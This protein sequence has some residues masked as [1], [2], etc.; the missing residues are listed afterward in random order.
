D[1]HA[2]IEQPDILVIEGLNILQPGPVRADG[3][4]LRFVS[5]FIDFSIY[6]DADPAH[7]EVW[8]MERFFHL[9][10]TAFRNPASFFRR[11]A[12]MSKDEAGRFGLDNWLSINLPN[13]ME[14][15]APSRS[16]ADLILRK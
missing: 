6:V 7:I 8:Y 12:E 13:L 15:I 1:D 10:E 2:I 11:Y 9:R 4:P 14:N 16:R 5:D 3:E